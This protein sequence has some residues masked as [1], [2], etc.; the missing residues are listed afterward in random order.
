[1]SIGSDASVVILHKGVPVVRAAHYAWAEKN[2]WIGVNFKAENIRGGK[3]TLTGAIP[4]LD[5]KADGAIRPLADNELGFDYHFTARKRHYGI[6]GAVLEWNIDLKSATFEGRKVSNPI[7]LEDKAGW[8]WPVGPNQT[9]TVRFNQP[10]DKNIFEGN[11]PNK[12]R[13]FYFAGDFE[14]GERQV[15]FTV[16]LPDGGRIAPSDSERY[17]SEDT[18]GWFRDA[19]SWD[20]SPIDLSF[21]N[22]KERPAGRHGV[23]KADGDRLVFEDGTPVRF[24]G[25]N[26]AA[27][28]L[29][30][31]S[32]EIIA[33]QAHRM[34]QLGFNLMRFVH[35][36][37]WINVFADNGRHDTRHLDPKALDSLDWWIKCLKDEGIY[38]WFELNYGR[39]L[40]ENDGVTV[41]FD[42]IKRSHGLV[43]GFSYFNQD[44]LRLM[45]EFQH[46]Y[47]NHVNR[48][49][50]LAYKDDPAI[51]GVLITN[52]NDLTTH[53]GNMMLPDK[54]NPV[55]NALFTE[56]FKAF[57]RKSGLPGDRI[58]RTWEP[59]PSK[60]FLNAMEHRFNQFMIEDLRN[61]GVR[62][63]L[64]TT[65]SWGNCSLF[66]LPALTEGDVIDVHAYG[67]A[68][69]LSTNPRYQS[70]FVSWI[71]AAQVQGKPLSITEWNVRFPEVDRFT[72]PLYIASI[73]SLQ[74]WDMPMIFSYSQMQLA[75]P[76][77]K[78]WEHKIDIWSSYSDPEL[79]GV[80][81]AAAVAFR[82]GHI[83]PARTNY[84]LMLD[85]GQLFD[86]D[87]NPK[88]A[89]TLRTLVE[90][91]RLTIG[92]PAVEELPWLRPTETPSDVTIVTDPMRDFIPAGQ[93]FVRS[94][95]GELLRN[96]KY[97]IQ[98]INTPKTQAVNG[99]VGGKTLQHGDAAFRI[100]TRKAVV[101]LTSIDDQPLSS[102]RFIL[103]TAI[104]RAVASTPGHVPF[105]SE[106]V[107]GTII[108]R[109]KISGLELLALGSGGKVQERLTPQ[110]GLEGLTI[111]LPT[112]RGTHWYL[113]RTSDASN[114]EVDSQTKS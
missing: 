89:A 109:T 61:L 52:E 81:P 22:A 31:T 47:L 29:F 101:A 10:L 20:G 38:V 67:S 82:R 78:E 73:A 51:V 90:Q 83:S 91:S 41:G 94:D 112:P 74:G 46:Q 111:R 4:E 24:W 71:G 99:W 72:A 54:N 12:I 43:T 5:L 50:R 84:C 75:A 13:T 28:A 103:I 93:S 104:A 114:E 106:P 37:S 23:L 11:N 92:L 86:Q 25:G 85:R 55:H 70:N 58:W 108:L 68:E 7:L 107:V 6:Y 59:G 21:L 1:M 113:L 33:C 97:G 45:Q 9:I 44:V 53:F 40:K 87:L 62:V 19:L 27:N 30:S 80:M 57:A 8:M 63:P 69:A 35:I 32:R 100:D 36:D 3:A 65:S 79:C 77:K 76:G 49:T 88:T 56:S 2:K 105:L 60:V 48:Y 14:P 96:W 39:T 66:S 15:S 110:S 16:H 95:T 34:S 98:T 18:T 26:I 102:S 42:E 64:A 17:G